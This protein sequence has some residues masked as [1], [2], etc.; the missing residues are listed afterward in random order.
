MNMGN[1][2]DELQEIRDKANKLIQAYQYSERS[3]DDACLAVLADG[4]WR[5]INDV[6]KEL[7]RGGKPLRGK[8]VSGLLRRLEKNGRLE[9][10]IAP[11]GRQRGEKIYRL[12]RTRRGSAGGV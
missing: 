5:N 6:Q 3:S 11:T 4:A 10:M 8:S 9:G 1:L 2:I 12:L 7:Q